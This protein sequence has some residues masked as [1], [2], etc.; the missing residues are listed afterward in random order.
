MPY[1]TVESGLMTVEQK[2]EL[3]KRLTEV[4]AEIMSIPKEFFMVTI[5]E[6][7][8]SNIGIGG[9]TIDKTR[10]E[11]LDKHQKSDV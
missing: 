8:D 3:I 9:K 6:L 7:P 2:E 11:Y 10:K 1:I 4:S 5:K